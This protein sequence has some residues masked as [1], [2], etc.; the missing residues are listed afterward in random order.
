[1]AA[2]VLAL[3]A[4]AAAGCTEVRELVEEFDPRTRPVE[5]DYRRAAEPFLR[6]ASVYRGPATEAH[7]AALPLNWPVRRAMVARRALAFGLSEVE[8]DELLAG[9]ARAHQ[10]VLA[11]AV[12]AYLPWERGRDLAGADPTYRAFLEDAEGRRLWPA[13]VRRVAERTALKES[14]YW[15]WGPWS[16]LYVYSF[17]RAPGFPA[18]GRCRLVLTGAPG[19]VDLELIYPK[20]EKP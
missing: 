13:D 4:L 12:S 5:E 15:F 7:F 16:R 6:R 11:V 2:L 8:A 18:E 3:A 14:L 17:R 20:G 10:E 1:M 19:R 9:Q